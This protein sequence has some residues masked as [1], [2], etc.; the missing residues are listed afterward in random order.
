MN[1]KVLV[2][3]VGG[4][5]GQGIIKSL[6]LANMSKSNPVKYTIIAADM[7]P[8]AAG[9][10][11]C[12]SGLLLPP[13][14]SKDYV[15]C[16]LKIAKDEEIDAIYVGSD[17][18]LL[19]IGNSKK[20]IEGECEAE[21]LSSPIEVLI[22]ARDKWRTF[23]FLR[24]NNLPVAESALPGEDSKFMHEFE[25]PV[26]VKPRE[27]YASMYFRL[28]R[29]KSEMEKAVLDIQ[30]AGWHPMLQEYLN[31]N[32]MEFTSGVTIDRTGKYVMSSIAIQKN[33][34]NGQTYKALID[35][36]GE[37]R[38][39]SEEVALKLGGRGAIN[40]QAKLVGETPKIFEINP[41]FSA[42]CP[43]RSVAGINEPDIVFRNAVMGEEI[44]VKNYRKLFCMRYWN[45]VYAE[46]PTYEKAMKTSRLANRDS[47]VLDYF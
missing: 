28:V 29:C 38:T 45:E 2:T 8:Q 47:F 17:E 19:V 10:Y 24:Q 44:E 36:Y 42:T 6:K 41:R 5:V 40:I 31:G 13:A 23:L 14:N 33:L 26:V 32:H 34:K 7:S 30:R 20:R 9:L 37:I 22:T 4:I 11:R 39:S 3:A 25:Y 1:A 15:D 27:G 12:D 35:D 46:L 43:M 18:E 16:V 21:V